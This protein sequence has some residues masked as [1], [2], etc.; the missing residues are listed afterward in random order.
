MADIYHALIKHTLAEVPTE[1][2]QEYG[3]NCHSAVMAIN[4]ALSLIGNLTFEASQS[5]DYPDTDAKRDLFLV[6]SVLRNLPRIA[7]ALEHNSGLVE[8]EM[9]VRNAQAGANHD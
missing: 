2:L 6:G 5:E 9:R 1:S 8:H 4:S 7:Q 3:D